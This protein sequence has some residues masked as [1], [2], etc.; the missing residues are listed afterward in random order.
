MMA[1]IGSAGKQW[2]GYGRAAAAGRVG[3][4]RV[5]AV[6]G[7][8]VG[9]ATALALAA[10]LTQPS[11]TT[12]AG[13]GRS[14][15]VPRMSCVWPDVLSAQP[16]NTAFPDAAVE[17]F[18]QPIVA[19]AGSRIVVSGRFP[20]PATP[21]SRFSRPTVP[22]CRCPRRRRPSRPAAIPCPGRSRVE[23]VRYWSMCVGLL[24]PPAPVVANELPGRR[25]RLRMPRR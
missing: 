9:L 19:P 13:G 24:S 20:M 16:D 25:D 8:A 10:T 14:A 11:G 22:A 1:G 12:P 21:R 7:M 15:I 5:A 23:D 6:T 2:P 4:G 3:P 18:C 17:H